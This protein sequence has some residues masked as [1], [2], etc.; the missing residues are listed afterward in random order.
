ML[1]TPGETSAS[2]LSCTD[3]LGPD[4]RRRLVRR[5]CFGEEGARVTVDCVRS[6]GK[7]ELSER[8][9]EPIPKI[10]ISGKFIFVVAA[11]NMLG[12]GMADAVHPY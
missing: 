6:D 4:D 11:A 5:C 8:S 9:H 3:F 12:K 7:R 10:N 2:F 1:D